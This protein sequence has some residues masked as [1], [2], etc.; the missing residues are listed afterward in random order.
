MCIRDRWGVVTYESFDSVDVKWLDDGSKNNYVK[1]VT[2]AIAN[3][4]LIE[5]ADVTKPAFSGIE[6]LCEAL[7]TTKIQK[8]NLSDIELTPDEPHQACDR[9]RP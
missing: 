5:H 4:E 6:A 9:V 1:D 8:L 7:P 2:A 3:K